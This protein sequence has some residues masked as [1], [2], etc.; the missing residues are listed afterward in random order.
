VKSRNSYG[1]LGLQGSL[2][3]TFRDGGG[4]SRRKEK[5]RFFL[6]LLPFSS[7]TLFS[8]P[9]FKSRRGRHDFPDILLTD[10][11]CSCARKGGLNKKPGKSFLDYLWN[12]K[13][14]PQIQEGMP[15]WRDYI[16]CSFMDCLC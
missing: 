4:S 14:N 6:K 5:P 8:L 3:G 9:G 1:F 13:E 15:Q 2:L 10:Q 7:T 11:S 12:E 16:S